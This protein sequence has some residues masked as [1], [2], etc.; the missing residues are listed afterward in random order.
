MNSIV[1]AFVGWGR[2]SPVLVATPSS[3]MRASAISVASHDYQAPALHVVMSS[4]QTRASAVSAVGHVM[5][6]L[7][8]CQGLQLLRLHQQ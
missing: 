7:G 1:R 2:R 3:L 4:R 8:Q 6:P 5:N